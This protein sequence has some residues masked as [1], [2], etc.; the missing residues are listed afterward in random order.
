MS[1][2]HPPGLIVGPPPRTQ[3]KILTKAVQRQLEVTNLDEVKT[4]LSGAL[5]RVESDYGVLENLDRRRGSLSGTYQQGLA[6]Q[7]D[8][9]LIELDSEFTAELNRFII[10]A[11]KSCDGLLK[12]L[13]EGPVSA[14]RSIMRDQMREESKKLRVFSDR[15][16]KL[17]QRRPP[18]Q[19]TGKRALAEINADPENTLDR[20]I[21]VRPPKK[22]RRV[23][24]VKSPA[25]IVVDLSAT[26]DEYVT[27]RPISQG[28]DHPTALVPLAL[29]NGSRP[30]ARGRPPK[31]RLSADETLANTDRA[32][33]GDPASHNAP[34]RTPDLMKTIHPPKKAPQIASGK[35]AGR[36]AGNHGASDDQPVGTEAIKQQFDRLVALGRYL[37]ANGPASG[38]R[39]MEHEAI[40]RM[41]G[42]VADFDAF[43]ATRAGHATTLSFKHQ[44]PT[45]KPK[46]PRRRVQ[47]LANAGMDIPGDAASPSSTHRSTASPRTPK[48]RVGSLPVELASAILTA[49]GRHP[50]V[51][52][53][54]HDAADIFSQKKARATKH[55]DAESGLAEQQHQV[56][57]DARAWWKAHDEDLKQD[58]S[59]ELSQ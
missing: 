45:V 6:T 59:F 56:V 35:H 21:T 16:S 53:L 17:A 5:E 32:V 15:I 24:S 34:I 18:P 22:V 12:G 23:G 8:Q 37:I 14:Q 57:M 39:R 49:S 25:R 3:Y 27:N 42:A 13:Q 40:A 55:V 28:N 11:S 33:V 31:N 20:E 38:K 10:R 52:A 26:D 7:L 41:H 47:A 9:D 46:K 19:I 4:L 50:F 58:A 1:H 30:R 29:A 54:N 51:P 36:V 44:S 48:L 2:G 43:A